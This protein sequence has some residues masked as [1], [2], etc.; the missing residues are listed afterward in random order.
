[1][2]FTIAEEGFF[3][4]PKMVENLSCCRLDLNSFV[5]KFRILVQQLLTFCLQKSNC[6]LFF[7]ML[8]FYI[9]IRG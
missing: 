4:H 6:F 1:M 9:G 3:N 7:N 8:C 5:K 2:C